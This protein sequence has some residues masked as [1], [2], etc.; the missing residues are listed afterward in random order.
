MR[1]QTETFTGRVARIGAYGE[2]FYV[3]KLG[4]DE[5]HFV[6]SDVTESAGRPLAQPP[7]L[8]QLFKVSVCDGIVKK[9]LR[10][11]E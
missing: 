11:V 4:S 7:S 3:V 5:K 6:M 10:V 1:G 2:F 8:G 9:A